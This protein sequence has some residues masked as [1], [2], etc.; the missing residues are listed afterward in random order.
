MKYDF[1]QQLITITVITLSNSNIEF[2]KTVLFTKGLF[3]QKSGFTYF[4]PSSPL[5]VLSAIFVLQ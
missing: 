5:L 3:N 4:L 2:E 1:I